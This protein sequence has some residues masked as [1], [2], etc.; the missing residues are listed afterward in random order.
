VVEYV[1]SFVKTGDKIDNEV[2]RNVARYARASITPMAA[3]FGG[4]VA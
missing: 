3:F 1:E 4:V 2:V